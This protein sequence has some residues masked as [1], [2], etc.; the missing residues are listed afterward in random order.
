MLSA[1]WSLEKRYGFSERWRHR[2]GYAERPFPFPIRLPVEMIGRPIARAGIPGHRSPLADEHADALQ[3]FVTSFPAPL[4]LTF[5]YNPA[6]RK[7]AIFP[8]PISRL[9]LTDR[10]PFGMAETG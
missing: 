5:S 6:C 1:R 7:L 10:L 2:Y 8:Y 9:G 4:I 3:R